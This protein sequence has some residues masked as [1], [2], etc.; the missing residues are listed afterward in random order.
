M[1]FVFINTVYL[2]RSD[3]PDRRTQDLWIVSTQQGNPRHRISSLAQHGKVTVESRG[4]RTARQAAAA[5][6]SAHTAPCA[7]RMREP[8]VPSLLVQSDGGALLE[9]HTMQCQPGPCSKSLKACHIHQVL[10]L[11]PR[12]CMDSMH[13]LCMIASWHLTR[14][15]RPL[16]VGHVPAVVP[17][18][19]YIYRRPRLG[20]RQRQHP[21][22]QPHIPAARNGQARVGD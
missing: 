14:P 22:R 19:D 15:R 13:D 5:P 12:V 21:Q 7:S 8:Q 20:C 4:G 18:H 3:R 9:P 6:T 1:C 16:K 17:A 2:S 10:R 11:C